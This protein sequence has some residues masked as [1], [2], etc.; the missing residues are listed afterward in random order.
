[1]CTSFF[2]SKQE[3]AQIL[4]IQKFYFVTDLSGSV[5]VTVVV[6]TCFR[7]CRISLM[8]N[9]LTLLQVINEIVIKNIVRCNL[10]FV[11][12]FHY[13]FQ[14]QSIH[15]HIFPQRMVTK[16]GVEIL[17][18]LNEMNI[19]IT[20]VLLNNYLVNV[21]FFGCDPKILFIYLKTIVIDIFRNGDDPYD[22]M[23]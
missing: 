7:T 11:W 14:L 19:S 12:H 6:T 3:V 1:M 17:Y 10:Y 22:L 15:G 18:F 5:L 9:F 21:L 8:I 2:I 23:V 13:Q 20:I 16:C 4:R